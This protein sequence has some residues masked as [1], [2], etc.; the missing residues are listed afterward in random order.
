[1]IAAWS[2]WGPKGSRADRLWGNP[3]RGTTGQRHTVERLA[4]KGGKRVLLGGALTGEL[5]LTTRCRGPR[6][7]RAECALAA[8]A[9]RQRETP[10]SCDVMFVAANDALE[11]WP[12]RRDLVAG[13]RSRPDRFSVVHSGLPLRHRRTGERPDRKGLASLKARIDRAGDAIA[14]RVPPPTGGPWGP[15]P[16][17]RYLDSVPDAPRSESLSEIDVDEAPSSGAERSEVGDNGQPSGRPRPAVM[18]DVGRLAGVSNQTVSRV[19][20]DS[21]H[22][23]QATRARVRAAMEELDYRPNS[24]ARALATGRTR[25]LG[26]V[27]FDRTLHGP[28]SI[29]SGIERAAHEE[30]YF[31]IASLRVLDRTTVSEAIGRL[32]MRGV[33]GILVIV[34]GTAAAAGLH[35]ISPELPVV[36][37]GA[38]AERGVPVVLI[39]Q[40]AGARLA[41]Q[42]L[43]D[44]GHRTVHHVTGPRGS[45][46]AHQRLDG[47]RATLRAAGAPEPAPLIGDW[48]AQS[49]Y[50]VGRQLAKDPELSAA[51]VGNDQMALGLLW[52][53]H[54]AGRRIPDEVSIVG[55]DDIPEAPYFTPPLTT[56]RQDFTDVGS[57][58]LRVLVQA[59]E[60]F[61][62]SE[63]VPSGS[64]VAPELV[65]RASTTTHGPRVT[66]SRRGRSSLE[67]PAGRARAR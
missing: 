50:Q 29:L 64:L 4:N 46:E 35:E 14:P 22:V 45:I 24:S 20:N 37:V 33:E 66:D 26:V 25:T 40:R 52:A 17:Q 53:L 58:S 41:T 32:R 67:V 60:T 30:G 19:I 21:R 3:A 44:L 8:D 11:L 9:R 28:A 12:T 34:S 18:A 63:P 38:G 51:F 1:M 55:F 16:G 23:R 13:V 2:S 36:A 42:H 7:G 10:Q 61:Q 39:D 54:E 6:D 56:V 15:G 65:V 43:L 57:R 59:I 27:S 5:G 47:W 31:I 48:S 49:G 62:G